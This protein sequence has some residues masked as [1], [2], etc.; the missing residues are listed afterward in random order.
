[1]ASN[2]GSSWP[3]RKPIEKTH[4]RSLRRRPSLT[5]KRSFAGR[6]I[7]VKIASR[8]CTD[9][10]TSST[11][12]LSPLP[13]ATGI[14]LSPLP[15]ATGIQLSPL[16]TATGIQLSPLP[17]ATRITLSPHPGSNQNS[18]VIQKKKM[19]RLPDISVPSRG[20]SSSVNSEVSNKTTDIKQVSDL[21]TTRRLTKSS[22]R[23]KSDSPVCNHDQITSKE[24][25]KGI[26]TPADFLEYASEDMD[27]DFQDVDLTID[28]N[29]ISIYF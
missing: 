22:E 6:N 26:Q 27:S 13:T 19:R 23:E 5:G 10:E 2:M 24:I 1:M 3:V 28:P 4:M 15:T 18:P 14:Q 21:P 9:S 25:D 29:T 20:E 16:P 7:D 8:K 12:K 17:T 11:T